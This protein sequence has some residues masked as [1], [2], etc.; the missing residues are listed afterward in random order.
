MN[1][2]T[3]LAAGR[4]HAALNPLHSLIYFAPEAEQEYTAAGLEAGRMPYFAGRAAAM[5]P[6]GA[7]VVAA[8]FYNFS[9]GLVARHI[10]RAWDLAEPKELLSAR[11]T[12]VDRALRR[13]LGDGLP[14]EPDVREAAG[15]A[16]TATEVCGPAGR[17]LYAAHAGLPVPEQ[18]HLAL[19]HA[20]TLLR[21]YRGDGHLAALSAAGLDGLEALIS[22]TATGK[23]FTPEFARQS[24]GWTEQE[25][26]AAKE[27]LHGRGLLDSAGHLTARGN[28]LRREVEE[29]TDRLALAPYAHLG[30]PGVER[31]TEIGSRLTRTALAAG[32]FPP[33]V[34]AQG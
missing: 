9:P 13:L 19:W 26:D 1:S 22:H 17:P 15:L 21:E 2:V 7:G 3:P 8:T 12:A 34:F 14:D 20:I 5:G 6:V 25:W 27:R 16:A 30:G 24:R 18:P 32:A 10:P 28:E 29:T 23:G 33:G 4:C 31:L 11:L